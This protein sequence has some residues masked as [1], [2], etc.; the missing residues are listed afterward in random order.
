MKFKSFKEY[1]I[2]HSK[3]KIEQI[4]ADKNL[5]TTLTKL[6]NKQKTKPKKAWQA[7]I[8]TIYGGGATLVYSFAPNV[9]EAIKEIQG[10]PYFKQFMQRPKRVNLDF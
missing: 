3:E 9:S 10:L 4:R 1:L 6:M 8:Y 7:K 2:E 5:T